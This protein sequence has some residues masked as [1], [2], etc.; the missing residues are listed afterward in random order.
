MVPRLIMMKL[1][2]ISSLTMMATKPETELPS[3]QDRKPSPPIRLPRSKV[4]A[5][6]TVTSFSGRLVS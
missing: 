4:E 3:S 5:P 6:N 1:Q 2:I